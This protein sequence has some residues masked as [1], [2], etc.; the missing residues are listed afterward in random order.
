MAEEVIITEEIRE[1]FHLNEDPEGGQGDRS[2]QCQRTGRSLIRNFK[3]IWDS[4]SEPPAELAGIMR[5]YQTMGFK[6]IRT[7]EEAGFGGILA[8]EMGLGKTL[9]TISALLY[10]YEEKKPG[11]EHP[12]LVVC[13]ASLVYNWQEEFA[14]FAADTR[15]IPITGG[16]A[17]SKAVKTLNA[18]HRLALTGTPIENR[19]SELWSI[20]D[21]LMRNRYFPGKVYLSQACRR[22]NCWSCWDDN[23]HISATD[24][25]AGLSRVLYTCQ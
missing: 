5:P 17:V 18:G 15:V 23:C 24:I 25:S 4:E 20:F 6:W 21:F 8:D 9:Q 13:P 16:A 1:K 14:K 22:R 19:L 3:T 12:S 11:T 10:D 7:L 2:P